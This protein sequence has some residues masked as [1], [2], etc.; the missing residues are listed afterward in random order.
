MNISSLQN[1]IQNIR[2]KTGVDDMSARERLLV[3]GAGLAILGVLFYHFILSPY[4]E[5]RHRLIK[6]VE[7][8]ERE[9]VEIQLLKQEYSELRIEEGG[10]KANLA[11]RA[12]G[13]TLFTFLDQQAEK[14]QVKELIKYMKPSV[15]SAEG[16]SLEESVVELKLQDVTLEQLVR[17]L[18]LTE[19]EKNVVSIK[20]LS[21]QVSAKKQGYLDVILQIVTFMEAA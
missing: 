4:I 21:I 11:K 16:G 9:L 5:A 18:N 15:I 14:S 20:R 7:L 8:Q 17:F 1:V 2:A 19:S 13:F 10:I 3:L 12:K 6:S